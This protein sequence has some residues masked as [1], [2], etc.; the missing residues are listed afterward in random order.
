MSEEGHISADSASCENGSCS[1]V[2]GSDTVCSS[3]SA[4]VNQNAG[5]SEPTSSMSRL[6]SASRLSNACDSSQSLSRTPVQRSTDNSGSK[7]SVDVPH[8]ASTS[9]SDSTNT[10]RSVECVF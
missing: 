10:S 9:M 8:T 1:N 7:P 6:E 5:F 3:G 4:S 2:P